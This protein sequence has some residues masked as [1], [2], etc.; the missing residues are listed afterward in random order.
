MK[1][2]PDAM[3]S[4]SIVWWRKPYGGLDGHSISP[5]GR[6]EG[7]PE[8]SEVSSLGKLRVFSKSPIGKLG[9][10]LITV[11]RMSLTLS[12]FWYGQAFG[13]YIY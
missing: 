5:E 12:D 11:L 7:S 3:L 9:T 6:Y 1:K 10:S 8:S 4:V 13:I 2:N